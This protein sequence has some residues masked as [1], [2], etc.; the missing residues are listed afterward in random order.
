M[1]F[2]GA[3]E[4]GPALHILSDLPNNIF[5][6]FL[7]LL[8]GQD[9]ERLNKRQ[10][11]INHGGQLACK[12]GDSPLLDFLLEGKGEIKLL[13]LRC[14]LHGDDILLSE[15]DA[16]RSLIRSFIIPLFDLPLQ[17]LSFILV[18]WHIFIPS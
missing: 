7:F 12:Y 6:Q 18:N 13:S 8:D 11:G 17:R 4:S 15:I 5:E 16:N 2:E 9:F 10:S 3:C 1:F 14:D